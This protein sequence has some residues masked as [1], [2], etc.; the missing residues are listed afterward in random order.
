M[1]VTIGI[2]PHKSTRTAVAIDG[3]ERPL[4]RLVL[5]ADRCSGAAAVGVGGTAGHATDLGGRIS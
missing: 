1:T 3:D 5:V 4:A 2:D